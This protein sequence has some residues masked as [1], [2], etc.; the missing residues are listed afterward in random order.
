[1]LVTLAHV[2]IVSTILAIVLAVAR[3]VPILHLLLPANR[4]HGSHRG[5][6]ARRGGHG[7]RPGFQIAG[8]GCNRVG[9][10]HRLLLASGRLALAGVEVMEVVV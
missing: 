3:D 9:G 6:L 7:G 2:T 10:G 8:S 1:M 5:A 4:S